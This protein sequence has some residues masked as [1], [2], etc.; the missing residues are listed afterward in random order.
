M[1]ASRKY[2]VMI[3]AAVFALCSVC[4]YANG[5]G[6][7]YGE[8]Y[9]E[10]DYNTYGGAGYDYYNAEQIHVQIRMDE[11]PPSVRR[12]HYENWKKTFRK[13]GKYWVIDELPQN[14]ILTVPEGYKARCVSFHTEAVKGGK[15]KTLDNGRVI[16]S[17]GT[18][19]K[20]TYPSFLQLY[21]D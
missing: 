4:A 6:E 8:Y 15:G 14:T 16:Y 2:V 1:N 17:A 18:T 9:N 3:L 20:Y 7:Y 5:G 10:D 13:D 19:E 11:N 12:L 21:K